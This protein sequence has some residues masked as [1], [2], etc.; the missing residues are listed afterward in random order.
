MKSNLT[1]IFKREVYDG[2]LNQELH[3]K[4]EGIMNVGKG[5]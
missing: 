3:D 4:K 2:L 5:F 1:K